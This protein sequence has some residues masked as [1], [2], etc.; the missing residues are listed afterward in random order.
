MG[1]TNYEL[2]PE[3]ELKD[4]IRRFQSLLQEKKDNYVVTSSG[5]KRVTTTEEGIISV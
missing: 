2:T 1:S 5:L 4:R 3:P